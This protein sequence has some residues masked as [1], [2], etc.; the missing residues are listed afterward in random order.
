MPNDGE[1][2]RTITAVERAAD[3]LALF[4]RTQQP[5]LGVT[6]IATS[7]GLS[8]AVVHRILTTLAGRDLVVLD[9]ETRRY[10]LGP[11]SLALGV[12][13]S[14]HI[15]VRQLA[16][17]WLR[18]LSSRTDETAT[19]SLRYGWRRMYV[20]Q[21]TP[22]REVRMTVSLGVPYPLHAGSSSKAFLAFLPPEERERYLA[23][24]VLEA[25]TDATVTDSGALRDD[26]ARVRERGYAASFGERQVGAGSVAAPVFGHNGDPTAV[27]SVCGPV[28]RF[29]DEVEM[30]VGH[31]LAATRELSHQLGFSPAAR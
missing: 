9:P 4:A 24:Q 10:R 22:G 11:L 14:D 6:E 2:R 28:E 29:G 12:A 3:V 8:K 26:L 30:A 17:P 1:T 5:G 19:L 13:Y 15:D 25:L 20:E 7:L 31:L 21:V 23:E 27:V 16:L 18:T